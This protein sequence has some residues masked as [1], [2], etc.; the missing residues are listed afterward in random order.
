[1]GFESS[2]L[3]KTRADLIAG[4]EDGVPARNEPPSNGVDRVV[5][6]LRVDL[7]LGGMEVYDLIGCAGVKDRIGNA[8][9]IAPRC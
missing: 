1:M 3:L 9:D 4:D 6:E 7:V 5:L 8:P 2:V